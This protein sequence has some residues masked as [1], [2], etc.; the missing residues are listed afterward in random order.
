MTVEQKIAKF[1]QENEPFYISDYNGSYSLCHNFFSPKSIDFC[2]SAFDRYGLLTDEGILRNGS[3]FENAFAFKN[4]NLTNLL[5]PFEEEID[6]NIG[7][8]A[9]WRIGTHEQ[10]G[11]TWLSDYVP[12]QL[13]GFTE[14]TSPTEEMEMEP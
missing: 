13:G 7:K 9:V 1:S 14:L 12:N 10:F 8:L 11:G 3:K 6:I 2:Q 5:F 4:G